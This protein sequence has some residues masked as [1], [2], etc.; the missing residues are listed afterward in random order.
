[1]GNSPK[2]MLASIEGRL[3][4]RTVGYA[5]AIYQGKSLVLST[6][7][8]W[9]VLNNQKMTSRI[10]SLVGSMSKTITA[11]A[12][13]PMLSKLSGHDLNVDSF[14][15]PYLPASWHKGPNIEQITFRM[16]LTHTSGLP[17]G[18]CGYEDLKAYIGQGVTALLP[19][20]SVYSNSGYCLLRIILPYLW[21]PKSSI[22]NAEG[23][24]LVNFPKFLGDR[25]V[26]HVRATVFD[27][28]GIQG[29]DVVP[30]GPT[31]YT[32]YYNFNDTTKTYQVPSANRLY[33]GAGGWI[34]SAREYGRFLVELQYGQLSTF[35]KIM[36]DTS[37]PSIFTPEP[38]SGATPRLGMFRFPGK[39]GYYFGHNGEQGS[40][41]SAG[42][43]IATGFGGWMV[44]PNGTTAVLLANSNRWFPEE[45]EWNIL[46]PAYDD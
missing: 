5:I 2:K 9:S 27:G 29:V 32:I 44:Y 40:F 20:P 21:A 7:G 34:L 24:P 11:G 6:S 33:A 38:D 3:K 17:N 31:P 8:G 41:S 26:E 25:Y 45:Q 28:A 15:L 36:R 42:T 16:L 13:I 37:A 10:R 1:M 22:D 12:V 23:N 30:N 35:W 46:L 14:I 4:G 43:A 39:E 19:A 18:G